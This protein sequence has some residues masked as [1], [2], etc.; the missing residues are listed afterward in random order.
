MKKVG[1]PP[2]YK[3]EEERINERRKQYRHNSSSYRKRKKLLK[4]VERC[5]DDDDYKKGLTGFFNK[6][7]YDYF[8]TGTFNPSFTTEELQNKDYSHLDY[9]SIFEESKK[10]SRIGIKSLKRYTEK[11][12]NFLAEKNLIDRGFVVFEQDEKKE[13]HTHIILKSNP[14]KINIKSI[15]EFVWLLGISLTQPIED[16]KDIEDHLGYM[17]KQ[18]KPSSHKSSDLNKVDSWFF[19][20]DFEKKSKE[21][22]LVG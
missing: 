21:L 8:F 4:T 19:V 3:T 17:V 5:N 10:K 7:D 15:S 9:Y 13:Y 16:R 12:I 14:E 20:G 6:F 2:K 11:Y 1:R 22:E 18:M